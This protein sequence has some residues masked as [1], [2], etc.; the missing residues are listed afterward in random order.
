MADGFDVERYIAAVHASPP[1][2]L[3]EQLADILAD[4]EKN[5]EK[6]KVF[7]PE[8]TSIVCNRAVSREYEILN[9]LSRSL[10]EVLA[11]HRQRIGVGT[12]SETASSRDVVCT[13]AYFVGRLQTAVVMAAQIPTIDV[14]PMVRAEALD[15]SDN[16]AILFLL[17]ERGP[18]SIRTLRL[19]LNGVAVGHVRSLA[20]VRKCLARLIP[21]GAVETEHRSSQVIYYRLSELGERLLEVQPEWMNVVLETYRTHREG[22]PPPHLP[23][24]DRLARKF[25]EIDASWEG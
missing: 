23:Y 16:Q 24:A 4:P 2:I 12:L 21:I 17:A 7:V 22:N 15:G 9:R 13:V 5:L 25:K 10:G 18:M 3:A 1:E 6:L 8:L 14:S 11:D 20:H 19:A